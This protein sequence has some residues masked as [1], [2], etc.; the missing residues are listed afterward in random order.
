[1]YVCIYM[2]YVVN[3]GCIVA[4]HSDW[5]YENVRGEIKLKGYLKKKVT[6]LPDYTQW[7]I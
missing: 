7:A 1:M 2:Y 5:V 6:F 3:I 4:M